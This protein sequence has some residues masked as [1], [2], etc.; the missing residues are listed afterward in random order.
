MSIYSKVDSGVSRFRTLLPTRDRWCGTVDFFR[1]YGAQTK[2]L[3]PGDIWKEQVTNFIRL[4]PMLTPSLTPMTAKTRW[5]YVPL[6]LVEPELT[7]LIITGSNNGKLSEETLPTF[8]SLA[9]AWEA[10]YNGNVYVQNDSIAHVIFQLPISS[11][12]LDFDDYD[13]SAKTLPRLYWLKAYCRIWWD[14]YRDE[15][16]DLTLT[17]QLPTAAA[18]TPTTYQV[19]GSDFDGFVDFVSKWSWC[20]RCLPTSLPKD[21]FTSALPWQLKG[22]SPSIAFSVEPSL[23][24]KR[25]DPSNPVQIPTS[26][27][28]AGFHDSYY[29]SDERP[30]YHGLITDNASQGEIDAQTS[31]WLDGAVQDFLDNISM[32]GATTSFNVSDLRDIFAQTRVFER[33]ARTGSRYIEYLR[34]NFGVAPS[35]GTLQRA[36]YLG[37]FSQDI[38]T[39]EVLQTGVGDTPVGTMRGHGI[40]SGTNSMKPFYNKEFG[41]LFTT[42]EVRPR[43]QYTQGIDRQL[44]YSSRY[45]FFNPSFQNLSEQE[46][47]NGELYFDASNSDSLNDETFGF[48]GMYNELRS[49]KER[50][51][52]QMIQTQAQWNQAIHFDSRPSL[53]GAFI[54]GTN[55]ADSFLRP[56]GLADEDEYSK[57][58]IIDMYNL[59]TPFRPMIRNPTPGLVDHS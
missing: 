40:S 25:T 20:L 38:L 1:L 54:N 51:F 55:Y 49:G 52:G 14:Y 3:I 45:E 26:I 33:L 58:V 24:W 42:F 8:P 23:T 11:T 39:T 29:I 12:F 47:R 50:M 27:H 46:V 4:N 34:A 6:R 59:N 2:W 43:I 53:N 10:D 32:R 57:P 36:Q 7:E 15:N 16:L 22:V 18:E 48:Q 35:D 41:M 44:T 56:F 30:A 17:T 5:F 37:G 19:D 9:S 13:W 21:Y 28:S 31:L